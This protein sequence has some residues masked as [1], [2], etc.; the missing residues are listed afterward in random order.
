MASEERKK[1]DS[2]RHR[3]HYDKPMTQN[4]HFLFCSFRCDATKKKLQRRLKGLFRRVFSHSIVV[5]HRSVSM[6][7]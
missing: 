7:R 1:A 6:M 2:Y 4:L 5:V 3:V